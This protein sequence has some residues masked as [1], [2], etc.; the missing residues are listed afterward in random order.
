VL[1]SNQQ[2]RETHEDPTGNTR[3]EMASRADR[4]SAGVIGGNDAKARLEKPTASEQTCIN[5]SRA[6]A[7]IDETNMSPVQV[8]AATGFTSQS[9]LTTAFRRATGFTP[10]A[11]RRGRRDPLRTGDSMSGG[12][13]HSPAAAS[14]ARSQHARKAT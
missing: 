3:G 11:Y 7:L 9:H 12:G 8:A 4:R 1:G 6:R 13:W 10:A 2:P 5:S 14:I